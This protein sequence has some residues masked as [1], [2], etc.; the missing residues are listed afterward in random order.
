MLSNYQSVCF[1][2]IGISKGYPRI[3]VFFI[4]SSIE[5]GDMIFH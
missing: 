2:Q 5:N 1:I 4:I 3:A